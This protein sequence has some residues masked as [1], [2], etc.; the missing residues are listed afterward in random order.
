VSPCESEGA[1]AHQKIEL[2]A[3]DLDALGE[4]LHTREQTVF[5]AFPHDA[6]R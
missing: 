4:I 5:I 1:N 3:T 2:F 6:A